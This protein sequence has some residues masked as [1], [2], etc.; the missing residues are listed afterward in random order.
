VA[1]P[2]KEEVQRRLRRVQNTAADRLANAE[3]VVVREEVD[4]YA[5]RKA[6][7]DTLENH[8]YVYRGL[9]ADAASQLAP[10]AHILDNSEVPRTSVFLQS[11]ERKPRHVAAK[12]LGRAAGRERWADIR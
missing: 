3:R 8:N 9:H 5:N 10:K 2:M 4:T 1:Y 12:L 6:A 7:A 11:K